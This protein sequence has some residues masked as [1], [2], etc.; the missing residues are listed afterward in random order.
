[1]SGVSLSLSFPRRKCPK[2]SLPPSTSFPPAIYYRHAPRLS[3]MLLCCSPFVLSGEYMQC[4]ADSMRR[5]RVLPSTQNTSMWMPGILFHSSRRQRIAESGQ[6][7]RQ[8]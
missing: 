5:D 2:P 3:G 1:M 4:N 7:S 8:D 6:H